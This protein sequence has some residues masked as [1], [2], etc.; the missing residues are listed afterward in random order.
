VGPAP[1]FLWFASPIVR[2]GA[3]QRDA[4]ATRSAGVPP[5]FSLSAFLHPTGPL[6]E[7][8]FEVATVP[9]DSFFRGTP[10][11][12]HEIFLSPL[13]YHGV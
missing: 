9:K 7:K 1:E 4:G 2:S 6:E 12:R 10:R 13:A 5:A 11:L 8:C 3:C